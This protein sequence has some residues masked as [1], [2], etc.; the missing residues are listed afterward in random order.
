MKQPELG[1]KIAELRK[2]RGLTQSELAK[3]CN[4]SLRTIQRIRSEIANLDDR[5]RIHEK[6]AWMLR[7]MLAAATRSNIVAEPSGA[8]SIAGWP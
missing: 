6:T 8:V 5:M 2:A 1:R 7:A 3:Q 4:L